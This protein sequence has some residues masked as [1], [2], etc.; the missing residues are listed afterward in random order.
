MASEVERLLLEVL[1]MFI[2]AAAAGIF[3][4][5][6]WE[7]PYTVALLLAGLAVAVLEPSPTYYSIR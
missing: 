5:K 6:V 1:S 7:F 2:I 4:A 3:V